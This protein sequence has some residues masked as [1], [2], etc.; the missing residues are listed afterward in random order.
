M[1][2]NPIP[3]VAN[4]SETISAAA[5]QADAPP[6]TSSSPYD[7][8]NQLRMIA[9]FACMAAPPHRAR[10]VASKYARTPRFRAAWKPP[11]RENRMRGGGDAP[12]ITLC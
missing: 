9:V 2:E 4:A 11:S 3:A 10:P 7:A 8:E 5:S 6:D 12:F 1:T